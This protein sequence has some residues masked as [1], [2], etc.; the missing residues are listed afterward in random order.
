MKLKRI[1][2][3]TKFANIFVESGCSNCLT[4]YN[5][6]YEDDV[7]TTEIDVTSECE[8]MPNYHIDNF[9]VHGQP[10]GSSG[11]FNLPCPSQHKENIQLQFHQ[12]QLMKFLMHTFKKTVLM[13]VCFLLRSIMIYA[14]NICY[15]VF[16]EDAGCLWLVDMPENVFICPTILMDTCSGESVSICILFL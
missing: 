7:L 3:F 2:H 6:V 13:I 1:L 16:Y 14:T 11:Y 4:F 9:I 15:L 5:S 8:G 12:I 10:C